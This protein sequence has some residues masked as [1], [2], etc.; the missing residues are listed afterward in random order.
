MSC[1]AQILIFKITQHEGCTVGPGEGRH[2]VV[3]HRGDGGPRIMGGF[4][5]KSSG[6]FAGT[7]AGIRPEIMAGRE[8][9]VAVEPR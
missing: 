2:G 7:P 4:I 9:G 8:T 5:Y 3:E 1:G 6:G